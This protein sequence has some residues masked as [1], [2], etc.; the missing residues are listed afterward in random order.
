[1]SKHQVLALIL[2]TSTLVVAADPQPALAQISDDV[3]KIGVLTDMSSVYS[4]ATGKGSVTAAQMAVGDFGGSV[5]GKT[6]EVISSD[7]QNKPDVGSSIARTWYDT[8]KVDV[9]VDVPTSS[10]ALAVQQITKEKNRVLL[11]SGAGSSDLT[12]PACSPN[13]IQW[14]YDTYALS[15]VAGKAMVKRGDDT[16]Y[17]ITADYAFGQALERDATNVVRANGRRPR[18]TKCS[19]LFLVPAS[20][21]GIQGKGRSSRQFGRRHPERDQASA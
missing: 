12:G 21:L 5:K 2:A 17:F 4:D 10:V 7:H 19:R 14:T 16:W 9:I 8:N 18:T 6:I 13:G 15:S 11:M 1:M 20:S 3:V